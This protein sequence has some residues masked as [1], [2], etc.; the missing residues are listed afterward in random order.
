M[1]GVGMFVRKSKVFEAL[2]R[3]AMHC[4]ETAESLALEVKNGECVRQSAESKL[5]RAQVLK[6][7]SD[8]LFRIAQ[9]L[10]VTP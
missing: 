10:G 8:K 9:E 5:A 6:S 2:K 1:E 7:C 3:E 4:I